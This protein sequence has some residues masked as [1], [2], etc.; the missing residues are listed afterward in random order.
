[1]LPLNVSK[2]TLMLSYSGLPL[3]PSISFDF[4]EASVIVWPA[5]LSLLAI[6]NTWDV[7]LLMDS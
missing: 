7:N 3:K 6:V 4:I 1:M 5:F 2:L